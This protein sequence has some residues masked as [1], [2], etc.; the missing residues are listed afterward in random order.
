MLE[1]KT[2]DIF[3]SGCEALVNTTN[4]VGVMGKGI[5]AQF[6]SRYPDMFVDYLSACQ[7]GELRIGKIHTYAAPDVWIINFPTKLDWRNPSKY[8]WID[9]GL[10]RLFALVVPQLKIKSIASP[11]LGC[12]NGGLS[13]DKVKPL[14]Q[15][16]YYTFD[17]VVGNVDIKVYEPL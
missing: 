12:S 7:R 10:A 3:E 17:D 14:I 16:W 1:F 5:A 13:W 15:K 6:K 8:A 2:G 11:G 4:C 9:V